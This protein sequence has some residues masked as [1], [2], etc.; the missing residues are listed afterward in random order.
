MALI[1]EQLSVKNTSLAANCTSAYELMRADK[2]IG[3]CLL[4]WPAL[5]GLFVAGMP[6]ISLV[7]IYLLGAFVMRSAGCVIN[8]FADYK[9][10]AQVARTKARPLAA[11]RASRA[12]AVKLF[13]GLLMVALV[14]FCQLNHYAQFHALIALVLSCLYPFVKRFFHAPQLILGLSFAWSIP[15]AFAQLTNSTNFLACWLLF[16]CIVCW[17]LAYDTQYALNDLA[18]DLQIGVKSSAIFFG[19]YV[20][21]IIILLQ[22][23]ALGLL[24]WLGFLK[25]Y[26]QEFFIL[27]II[28][29]LALF[30]FQYHLVNKKHYMAAFKHNNY[31]GLLWLALIL[32]A[33]IKAGN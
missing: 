14:L 17:V 15:L 24:M 19:N 10:D 32:F 1:N 18:D 25:H 6:A 22:L 16:A 12:F 31:V 29:S 2:P 9:F 13:I 28:I 8:D 4:L 26:P 3:F 33:T 20:K 7:I 27:G 23:L 21:P 30:A 11:G 5:M